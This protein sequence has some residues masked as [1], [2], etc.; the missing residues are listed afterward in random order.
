[1]ERANGKLKQII[2][3]NKEI[4][5]GTWKSNLNRAVK[6]YNNYENRTTGFSP[7]DASKLT[8]ADIKKLKDNVAK[9]QKDENRSQGKAYK[10]GDRVRL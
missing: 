3:K 8:G 4:F 5:K 1:M 9:T 10:V 7:S 6:V 2:F